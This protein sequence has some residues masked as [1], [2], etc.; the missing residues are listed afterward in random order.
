ML[1][2]RLEERRRP[3]TRPLASCLG[4]GGDAPLRDPGSLRA[5]GGHAPLRGQLEHRAPGP[6]SC[7]R[8]RAAPPRGP[9]PSGARHSPHPRVRPR[10]FLARRPRGEQISATCSGAGEPGHRPP[11]GAAGQQHQLRER[12]VRPAGNPCALR[13]TFPPCCSFPLRPLLPGGPKRGGGPHASSPTQFS[14]PSWE[15]AGFWL[16]FPLFGAG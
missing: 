14:G 6:R 16:T 8:G 10:L 9:S 12:C 13:F 2:R 15:G 3:G 1:V 11:H 5:P 4:R 7:P